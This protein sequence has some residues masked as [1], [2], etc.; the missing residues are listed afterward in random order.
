MVEQRNEAWVKAA[1]PEQR[2]AAQSAGELAHYLGGTT[3]EEQAQSAFVAGTADRVYAAAYGLTV[4][5]AKG[6]RDLD[7]TWFAAK[8]EDMTPAQREKL[9]WVEGAT[10]ADVYAAEQAGELDH[11]LGREKPKE[12]TRLTEFLV[13]A[14]YDRPLAEKVVADQMAHQL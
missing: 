3:P 10:P 7:S 2:V 5:Q 4:G 6:N 1:T 9:S 11:L 12:A 13:S 14:G 8:R